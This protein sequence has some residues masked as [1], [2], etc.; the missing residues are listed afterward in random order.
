MSAPPPAYNNDSS[1]SIDTVPSVIPTPDVTDVL[2]NDTVKA[3]DSTPSLLSSTSGAAVAMA[4]QAAS[5]FQPST[6]PHEL[7]SFSNALFFLILFVLVIW[8]VSYGLST[9][10]NIQHIKDDWANQRCSPLIM[11]FASF[12]DVDT[13]DNFEFC[14]GKIFNTHSQGYLGSIGG[15]A[16]I[17]AK[18]NI[19]S[20]EVVDFEELGMEAV[21]KITVKD[22]PAFIITDNK[23]NDF[24]MNL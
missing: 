17:L 15:P 21:R 19:L 2:L 9:V 8:I 20:V 4:S 22:F 3:D 18:E 14:M 11:P 1:T 10:V 5:Y 6:E 24:F 12:F 13:K 16:A 7:W 23:G